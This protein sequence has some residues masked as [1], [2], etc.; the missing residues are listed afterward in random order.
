M[1]PK[2]VKKK[3]KTPAF[4]AAVD[5][6]EL[7]AGAEEL[8][9]DFDEHLAFVIAA[10]EDARR[11]ARARGSEPAA[12]AAAM[13]TAEDRRPRGRRDRPG[14]ARAGAARARPRRARRSSSSSSASTSRSSTGARPA[15]RSSARPRAAMREAGFGLK[16]ATITPEGKDDVGSPNRIL[17][18]EVGGKVIVRTGPADPGRGRARVRRPPPDLGRAHG[19]RGRLRRQAVARGRRGRAST[20]SRYRTEKITRSTCRAVAEYAFRTAERIGR[21]GLRR[22]EVDG[23][24]R[25]RGDAQ[26]GDGRGGRAPSRRRL[27]A[28]AD[29]RHLRRA[30]DG[31]GRHAAR[32]PGAQPRRRLPLGPR[33]ADVRLDRG[34]RVGPAGLRRRLRRRRRDGRGAA[35]HRAV[36]AWARTSPTRWR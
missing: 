23:L 20:R 17:R 30:D 8:G 2:S 16:A 7:R 36:A 6:D 11:R 26:G 33:A 13:A 25:L 5:R 31:R 1:T 18:E 32:D 15:T 3:M 29:R 34:R 35:R 22:A 12:D 10:L 21:A 4:A 9:V 24:P 27:P 19:G 28:G 14:A